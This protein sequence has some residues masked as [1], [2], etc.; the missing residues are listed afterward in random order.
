[1]RQPAGRASGVVAPVTAVSAGDAGS[2]AA[3]A[4]AGA[5][6][7]GDPGGGSRRSGSLREH[8][9][10]SL[11]SVYMDGVNMAHYQT[12]YTTKG[13]PIAGELG[14]LHAQSTG[15]EFLRLQQRAEREAQEAEQEAEGDGARAAPAR[16]SGWGEVLDSARRT[17]IKLTTSSHR[18]LLKKLP[19]MMFQMMFGHELSLIHI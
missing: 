8:L 10:H 17:V 3:S 5:V 14:V 7:S 9:L 19:E 4:A 1:M 11:E 16:R 18:A 12:D 2:I 15:L 6:A 13:G